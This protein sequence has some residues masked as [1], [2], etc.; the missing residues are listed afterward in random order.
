LSSCPVFALF[1]FVCV[2]V[3]CSR[4]CYVSEVRARSPA[5]VLWS[6]VL[7]SA[8]H[9]I[10]AIWRVV[11]VVGEWPVESVSRLLYVVL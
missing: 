8:V 9:A 10:Q 2:C 1:Y 11:Y 3:F 7:R 5:L 4:T 6:L